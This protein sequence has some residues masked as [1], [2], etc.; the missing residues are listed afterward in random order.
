MIR[1]PPR[2]TLFPYTTLFRSFLPRMFTNLQI[3]DVPSLVDYDL[4]EATSIAEAHGLNVAVANTITT[5]DR[6]RGTV[7]SQDPQPDRR[8]RKG[9]DVKLTISAGIR[10]PNVVGKPVDEA[11]AILVRAG[12]TVGE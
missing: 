1:R 6:P 10:P 3:T 7:I 12:W 11:R 5:D 9:N 4:S 8:V 2:S